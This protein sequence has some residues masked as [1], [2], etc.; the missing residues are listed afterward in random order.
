LLFNLVVFPVSAV[1]PS[2]VDIAKLAD[3]DIV[4][5]E[6]ASLSEV[7]AAE[8]FQ[9]HY[10]RA[11][12]IQ[13]PITKQPTR[14]QRHIFIGSSSAMR[15][16]N[17]GFSI[18]EFGKEDFRII[19]RNN[20]IVIAGGRPRGTLYGVYTFLEDYV[21]VRFLT[22]DHTYI[23]KV[24][25]W[26]IVDP[27][28][29]FC[30]PPLRCRWS[31]YRETNVNP[32]FAV[33][34][35]TN[36][37][38]KNSTIDDKLGGRTGLDLINH[39]LYEYITP[40][41][42]GKEHPE[43]F[44]MV[45]GERKLESKAISGGPQLCLSNPEVLRIT[46]KSVLDSLKKNPEIKNISISQN[47]NQQYC[48]CPCCAAIDN[49]EGTPMGSILTF[50][51]AIADEVAKDFPDVMVGTLSYQYSRK[52]PKTIKPRPN[53]QIQLCS[54]ESCLLHS[55]DNPMCPNNKQ[56]CADMANWGKICNNISIW[57]Y[58]TI[59]NNYLL[60]LPNLRTIEPNIRYFV[61]NNAKGVFMQSAYTTLGAEMSDLRN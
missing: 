20:D 17:I 53:I 37:T 23:P 39:S 49:R 24:G 46:V 56:F 31:C 41:E 25:A 42:Y 60:P 26:R 4:L 10:A 30:H 19:V 57:S 50:V 51:N 5:A 45:D 44:A 9:S 34:I 43:Y 29:R 35:R 13:L 55:I 8:E 6:D 2:G 27:L 32:A 3:W 18:E 22:A 47:D 58:N 28:D 11:S 40:K 38:W 61:A 16:S 54:I 36:W 33:R 52:P 59:F 14:L 7:Y 1:V 15:T 21:G 12:G 48:R